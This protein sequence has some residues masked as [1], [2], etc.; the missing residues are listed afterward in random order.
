MKCR[1]AIVYAFFAGI[2]PAQQPATYQ[3]WLNRG[4]HEFK[5]ARYAEAEAAFVRAVELNPNEVAPLL[6]LATTQMNRY[7]PGA[8]TPENADAA[9]RA[10]ATFQ[11]VLAIEP[12]NEIA[13]RSLASFAYL[14]ASGQPDMTQKARHL[15]ES[16]GRYRKLVE[17]NPAAKD[18]WYSLGVIAWARFYPEYMQARQSVNLRPED[19]GPIPSVN[20]RNDL[21]SRMGQVVEDGIRHLQKA[22]ELDPNYDDAMAYMNLLIRERADLYD[23]ADDYK[24]E[25]EI[26]DQWVRKALETKRAKAAAGIPSGNPSFV[27]AP[28]PPAPPPPGVQALSAPPKIAQVDP[29]YPDEALQARIQGTVRFSVVIGKDGRVKNSTLLSGHPLLVPAAIDALKQNVY[30]PV[31]LNGQPAELTFTDEVVF[32]LPR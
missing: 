20:V 21:R 22:L 29:V 2:L 31:L 18:A 7:A 8:P 24:R 6:Y 30:Q 28:P 17:V 14:Q 27:T 23:T 4:V 1:T 10:E 11:R 19:P 25:I 16:A 15:E 32:R 12:R 13:L 5:A 3:E 9:R 26:A